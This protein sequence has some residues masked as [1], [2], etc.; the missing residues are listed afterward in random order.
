MK[1]L[2]H[3]GDPAKMN[4]IEGNTPWGTVKCPDGLSCTYASEE[5]RD[6]VFERF[7]F[8]NETDHDLFTALRICAL[9]EWSGK[10]NA[11]A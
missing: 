4:W 2:I 7:T 6:S 5:K 11:I 3:P 9:P 1:Q 10:A 8:R